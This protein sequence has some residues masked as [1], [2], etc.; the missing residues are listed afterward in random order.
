[1]PIFAMIRILSC[2][3]VEPEGPF[4]L[5]SALK[6]RF[7]EVERAFSTTKIASNILG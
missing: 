4:V 1:M 3:G 7:F 6:E 2:K 5:T